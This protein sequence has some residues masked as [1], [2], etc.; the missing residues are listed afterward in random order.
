MHCFTTHCMHT[1]TLHY[2]NDCE[3]S[4]H[5]PSRGLSA[6]SFRLVCRYCSEKFSKS[7]P[8]IASALL[9]SEGLGLVSVG[10]KGLMFYNVAIQWF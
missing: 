3:A 2:E 4:W 6:S 1:H 10:S 9:H 5:S 8:T 7:V